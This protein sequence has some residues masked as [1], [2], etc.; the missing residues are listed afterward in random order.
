M[1]KK[2]L[3]GLAGFLIGLGIGYAFPFSKGMD[4][5]HLEQAPDHNKME[6]DSMHNT[7]HMS[8]TTTEVD[9][10]KPIPTLK[11]EVL[12]DT[13]DGYNVHLVTTNYTWSPLH[14]N[15]SVVQGEGHAHIYINDLKLARVY[16]EWF[17]VPSDKLKSGENTIHVT[18][19]ANDHSEWVVDNE[20]IEEYFKVTK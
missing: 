19:N 12:K 7:T 9:R 15:Q 14:V 3:V 18:L 2:F 4:T 16:G 6:S 17:H 13:K 11:L 10:T 5:S 1:G 8:H 20:H